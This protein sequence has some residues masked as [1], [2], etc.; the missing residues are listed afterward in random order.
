VTE[1]ISS[2]EVL[3]LHFVDDRAEVILV[4]QEQAGSLAK[5]VKSPLLRVGFELQLKLVS[6]Q[7]RLRSHIFIKL[8]F[9]ADQLILNGHEAAP[10]E[11]VD[12]LGVVLAVD[13]FCLRAAEGQTR[14]AL[15]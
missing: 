9:L 6:S 2:M 8:S 7:D 13:S 1:V 4:R 5:E 14:L 15:G 11:L 12:S 10:V 3:L